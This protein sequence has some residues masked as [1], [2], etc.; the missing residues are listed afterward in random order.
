MPETNDAPSTRKAG[1][2]GVDPAKQASDDALNAINRQLQLTQDL[3][4]ATRPDPTVVDLGGELLHSAAY[5]GLQAPVTSLG[6]VADNVLHRMDVKSNLGETLTKMPAPQH[7]DFGT[8]RWHAQQIGGAGGMILPFFLTKGAL[9]QSGLSFAA[10]TEVGVMASSRLASTANAGL[11]ADGAL[12]G[13]AYDFLL[14]PVEQKDM[15]K[16]WTART[17]HGLTG[18]ATFGT[19]TAGSV[20]LR[21]ASRSMAASLVEAPKAARV[22]YDVTMGALPGIPAGI[23]NAEAHARL[24]EGRTSSW[25]ERKQGAYTMFM[26]GGALSAL[27]TIPGSEVPLGDIA[28][29]YATRKAG[30]NNLSEMLAARERAGTTAAPNVEKPAT[31]TVTG[32]SQ[33]TGGRADKAGAA[34][35]V[36]GNL[37]PGR[38]MASGDVEKA[39][40]SSKPVESE[41]PAGTEKPVGPEKTAEAPAEK[42]AQP[43]EADFVVPKGLEATFEKGVNLAFKASDINCTPQEVAEFFN[44]ARTEGAPLK[45][46]MAEV[47]KAYADDPRM[48]TLIREA[49]LP[50][51][52]VEHRV[53][54]GDIKLKTPGATMDQFGRWSEFMQIVREMPQDVN[55]YV[56]FRH[57]VFRWLNENKDMHDWARQYGEQNKY[58]KVAGPLDYYFGTS[59]LARFVDVADAQ[60]AAKAPGGE[61]KATADGKPPVIRL[62]LTAAE[63]QQ[64]RAVDPDAA[65]MPKL[66]HAVGGNHDINALLAGKPAGPETR[67]A[68]PLLRTETA[69]ASVPTEVSMAQKMA[70]FEKGN[71]HRQKMDAMALSENFGQMTTEQFA[72]WLDYAY[73]KPAGATTDGATNLRSLWINGRDALLSPEVTEAYKQYRGFGEAPAV[74]QPPAIPLEAVRQFLSAPKPTEAQP[75]PEWLN[76]YVEARVEQAQQSA[77]PDAKPHEVLDAALPRWLVDGLRQQHT[78]DAK[79]AGEPPT[80]K[81]TLPPELAQM[82]EAARLTQ[83]P[84]EARPGARPEREFKAPTNDA[85][86]RL[87]KL[88]EIMQVEDPIIRE[89]L[90]RLGAVD[91]ASLRSIMGKLDPERA[92]PEYQDLLRMVL[93]KAENANDVK[94]LLD[95]IFFGNKNHRTDRDSQ[96]TKQ[97]Q[98]L[99]MAAAEHIVPQADP[100]FGKTQQMVEDFISGKIRDPRPPRFGEEPARG[101]GFDR[102]GRGGPEQRRDAGAGLVGTAKPGGPVSPRIAAPPRPPQE[103]V[104]KDTAPEAAPVEV[105]PVKVEAPPVQPPARVEAPPLEV[106]P[107]VEAPA[108][109]VEA[110]VEPAPLRAEPPVAERVAEPPAQTDL[111]PVRVE[112]TP[113]E[114]ALLKAGDAPVIQ[115]KVEPVTNPDGSARVLPDRVEAT[116][117]DAGKVVN[118]D[119]GEKPAAMPEA[120]DLSSLRSGQKIKVDG[121]S[122]NFIAI[123]PVSGDPLVRIGTLA[124]GKETFFTTK[125]FNKNKLQEVA[126]D[127]STGQKIFRDK[128]G[129]FFE[130]RE[131]GP[132]Y[133]ATERP[134]Y[135]LV[136]P[137]EIK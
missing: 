63:A 26:A 126:K 4:K 123:D 29:A 30:V 70:A 112:P 97:H 72:K 25:E 124:E 36:K 137:G 105:P 74:G 121:K 100:N 136:K 96:L 14:R 94:V 8:A 28:R 73:A 111:A 86:F 133:M 61:S 109:R 120:R 69:P 118:R 17:Q 135:R 93:P 117:G 33:M 128:E 38:G 115:V 116:A 89:N 43:V 24:S 15:D 59:N 57:D 67:V 75:L 134:E 78:V 83:P 114:A 22:A 11:I 87:G 32:D 49:Y 82:M 92:A 125:Q 52:G 10:R 65:L 62:D 106:P 103:L 132:G 53:I 37:K 40:G 54:E 127:N 95:A 55:G 19:L 110:P 102:G 79:I 44:F 48:M 5:S 91:H 84:K 20:G 12:T 81:N 46:Q 113:A 99:A 58:S 131:H 108:A 129:K 42:V 27:H 50:P 39:P 56:N 64:G 88:N 77:K 35:A 18:A 2:L 34:D 41:K 3:R 21:H 101:G 51:K 85:A 68:D 104:V 6:Q 47:A 45:G 107:A 130:V 80:Y 23:V 16:F 76:F 60:A 98:Q 66:D 90:L 7:E 31:I 119:A 1:D 13:F 122:A 9:K 71:P